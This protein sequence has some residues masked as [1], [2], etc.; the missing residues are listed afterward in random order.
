MGGGSWIARGVW[1]WRG[2]RSGREREP[3]RRRRRQEKGFFLARRRRSLFFWR[4]RRLGGSTALVASPAPWRFELRSALD[5]SIQR[6]HV[7][8]RQHLH[9]HIHDV[10][11]LQRIP[12]HEA[13]Q[14]ERY[15]QRVA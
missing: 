1:I 7:R 12:A 9:R 14:P 10:F 3:P 13:E 11:D 5:Q 2:R 4:L 15:A 6:P 8:L